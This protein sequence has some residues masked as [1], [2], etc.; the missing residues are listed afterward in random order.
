MGFDTIIDSSTDGS[1]ALF[2][3]ESATLLIIR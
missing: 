3:K 2:F 1:G